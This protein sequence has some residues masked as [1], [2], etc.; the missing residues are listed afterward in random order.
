L[1]LWILCWDPA[2]I[3]QNIEE[4]FPHWLCCSDP[5]GKTRNDGK[6]V[7]GFSMLH[8]QRGALGA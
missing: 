6:V 3:A 5:A 4:S 2:E 8:R 7:A 1:V